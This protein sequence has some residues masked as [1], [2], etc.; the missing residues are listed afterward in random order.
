VRN[1]LDVI[2]GLFEDSPSSD[3]RRGGVEVFFALAII[4][5]PALDLPLP[6]VAGTLTLP[7]TGRADRR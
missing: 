2:Q 4:S 7:L 5:L 6:L 1:D 3:M